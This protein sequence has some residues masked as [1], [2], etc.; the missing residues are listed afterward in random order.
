VTENESNPTAQ[1]SA[2]R[3]LGIGLAAGAG[4][5]LVAVRRTAGRMP[6]L[7][8]WTS[9]LAERHGLAAAENLAARIQGRYDLLIPQRPA[10]VDRHP[11]LKSRHFAQSI[12]PG[13]A[14]YQVLSEDN[15]DRAAVLEEV[16][17]LL[18]AEFLGLREVLHAFSLLPPS[19]DRFRF[20][21]RQAMRVL[22]PPAGWETEW[23]EDSP[24]R[25]AFN[26][27]RCFYLDVLPHYG[28]PE[29]PPLYCRLDDLVYAE[30]PPYI[31]FERGKTL[32]RGDTCCDFAYVQSNGEIP[33]PLDQN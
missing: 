13:V 18:E 33:I 32:G 25:I 1:G 20:I 9:L 26:M 24:R 11:V 8:K 4:L 27:R 28:V 19:F 6:H 16:A 30:L 21:V 29:L 14:L 3:L 31:R 7:A 15:P 17:A 2:L 22:Y 10:L 12:L 5:A 23:V